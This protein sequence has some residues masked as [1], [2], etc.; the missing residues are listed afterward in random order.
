MQWRMEQLKHGHL[1]SNNW[2][3]KS[4]DYLAKEQNSMEA[5]LFKGRVLPDHEPLTVSYTPKFERMPSVETEP[6]SIIE[7]SIE[8]GVFQVK[9]EIEHYTD[10]AAMSLFQA[11]WD[12][13]QRL[14]NA[15]GFISA[16]PYQTTVDFLLRPDGSVR[17]IALGD[18]F[19]R[20]LGSFTH[21]DL[22]PIADLI[23]FDH[24]FA[25]AVADLLS[26][27]N[28][29]HYAPI[30]YGRVAESIVRLV[31][32]NENQR[33]MWSKA[34]SDL[35]VSE[36]FLRALTEASTD[37]RHGN[38]TP[39]SAAENRKLSQMAWLLVHRYVYYRLRKAN[40][41]EAEFPELST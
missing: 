27:L 29:T 26:M 8:G 19:L 32:P 9:V 23:I 30:S 20:S 11:A 35:R 10:Q 36:S 25:E 38:R 6:K 1:T 4:Y 34:R 7:V 2:R 28:R 24:A 13:A 37:S 5:F 12:A 22:E 17:T 14:A 39:I 31:A 40:L 15:A 21:D 3:M 41:P 16:I 33:S 18:I